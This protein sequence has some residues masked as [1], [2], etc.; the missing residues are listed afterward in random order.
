MRS[1]IRYYAKLAIRRS[2]ILVLAVIVGVAGS[3]AA[4]QNMPSVYSSTATLL[5]EE[6]Q[7]ANSLA[8]STVE[9]EAS[10]HVADGITSVAAEENEVTLFDV[11]FLLDRREL[12]H[13]LHGQFCS[14]VGGSTASPRASNSCWRP[15]AK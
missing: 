4:L 15:S 8:T 13:R 3:L 14:S 7:I 12:D 1:E 5:V 6:A 10:E 11:E 2:W 9:T